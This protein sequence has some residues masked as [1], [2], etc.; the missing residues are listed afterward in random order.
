MNT[1]G[2]CPRKKGK[3]FQVLYVRQTQW[4][5]DF[6][7]VGNQFQGN[8]LPLELSRF[9]IERVAGL[10]EKELLM[11]L[12]IG[13]LYKKLSFKILYSC[14]AWPDRQHSTGVTFPYVY[15]KMTTQSHDPFS[16][17]LT[18]VFEFPMKQSRNHNSL[19][20]QNVSTSTCYS[21]CIMQHF[22]ILHTETKKLNPP[23][24]TSTRSLP[25]PFLITHSHILQHK[26]ARY[27]LFH[28]KKKKK[29]VTAI[30]SLT[31]LTSCLTASY[32]C[33]LLTHT[34]SCCV[35]VPV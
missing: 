6:P 25:S 22:S 32:C 27:H 33:H 10:R 2:F 18:S 1:E 16:C 28:S 24:Q 35:N 29:N 8:S 4:T 17:K 7:K 13:I 30:V 20:M 15:N 26:H 31:F 3:Q 12:S 11:K 34:V 19:T 23:W 14:T 9:P 5:Q 21:A